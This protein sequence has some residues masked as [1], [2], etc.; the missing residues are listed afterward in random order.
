MAEEPEQ[1]AK[2]SR[3]LKRTLDK[4]KAGVSKRWLEAEWVLGERT[5]RVLGVAAVLCVAA[6]LLVLFL[7]WYVAP[8]PTKPTERK[9]LVQATGILLAALVGLGGLYFTWRNLDQTRRTTQRTLELT[10][11]GQITERFTRAIDQLGATDDK[12]N[13]RLEIQ[14]GGIYALE[15]IARD[16][17]DDR[18]PIVE[19][20]SAYVRE[21]AP[22]PPRR[23]EKRAKDDAFI[24]PPTS[25]APP[26]ASSD[27]RLQQAN[28][29]EDDPRPEPD[30]QVVLTV[31]GRL[32]RRHGNGQVMPPD[33]RRTDLRGAFLSW[34]HLEGARL[35]GAHLEGAWLSEAHLEGAD[36][37]EARLEG[38]RLLEA[39]L[40][41]AVLSDAHLEGAFL[42]G[43][44]GLTREQIEQANGDRHTQL[45]EY[46]YLARPAHWDQGPD[47]EQRNQGGIVTAPSPLATGFL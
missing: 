11:R 46:L 28:A 36:L 4:A 1:H 6:V 3:Y 37:S 30:V 42:H 13:K 35:S 10:E 40:E 14:L 38:A 27:E 7:D 31:L 21:H 12:G 47:D 22:W 9:D 26:T 29:N 17:E 25:Q 23:P 32:P 45:P 16:S 18:G 5:A 44:I 20:L 41:G 43:A 15:R 19:V 8:T 2:L 34:A 39:H 24:S 33:L